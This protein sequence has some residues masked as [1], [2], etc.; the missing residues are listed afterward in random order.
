MGKRT[1]LVVAELLV[2]PR[3]K[4]TFYGLTCLYCDKAN[5]NVIITV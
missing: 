2:I 3:D 5:L 1:W 4:T